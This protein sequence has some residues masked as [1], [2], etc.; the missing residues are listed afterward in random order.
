MLKVISLSLFG[1]NNNHSECHTFD[2]F[3]RFLSINLRAA[4]TIFNDWKIYLALDKESYTAYQGYFDFCKNNGII[5]YIDIHERRQLTR[6][7]LWRVIPVSWADYTICRD[8]DSL[9]TYRELQAVNK[10]IQ[11][12]T[13]A[14]SMNDSLGHTIPLLGGMIGF[15]K[16]AFDINNIDSCR[17]DYSI[18]GADQ[19]YLNQVVYPQVQNSITEHRV[20]G[21][22]VR[23]ENP[24]SYNHIENIQVDTSNYDEYSKEFL[25][26]PELL[27]RCNALTNHIGCGGILID[28]VFNEISNRKY[29]G[30]LPFWSK[31]CSEEL[32]NKLNEIEKEYPNVFYWQKSN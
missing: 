21:M 32:N 2:S 23:S 10:W 20:I 11:N 19:D 17:L 24:Y 28:P 14:H 25:I 12:G 26:N 22:P 27:E 7:M 15:R 30:A 29:E 16:N 13:M 6:N 5:D 4:K 1:Y 8:I 9:F 31:H 3:I 18:K